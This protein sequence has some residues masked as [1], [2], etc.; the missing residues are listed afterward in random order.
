MNL[1]MRLKLSMLDGIR[2]SRVMRGLA[3]WMC[4]ARAWASPDVARCGALLTRALELSDSFRVLDGA[5]AL[6]ARRAPVGDVMLWSKVVSSQP[7][8]ARALREDKTLSRSI[9][10]KAPG[11]GG[12]KGVLLM[13]FEY[14]WARLLL[15]IPDEEFHW[16]DEEYDLV[17]SASWSATDYAVLALAAS[18]VRGTVFVQSCN[19]EEVARIE[20]FHPRLKCLPTLP[21]DWINPVLYQPKPFA[22]RTKDIVMVANW[23]EF[24]RHWD[25]FRAL[26]QLPPGLKVVLIG[27]KEG[28]RDKEFIRRLAR[29]FGAR[30]E[31]EIH[32]SIPIHAVAAHQ[33]DAKVSVIM[34]RREGCCVAAVESL[35]AGCALAMR[36]DA[37][38]GPLAYI[39]E[40]TGARLRPGRIAE[41]LSS[42]LGRAGQLHP[43]EWAVKNLACHVSHAKVNAVLRDET[44][45]AGR[46]WTRDIVLPQWRPHPTFASRDEQEAMRPAYDELHA[47]WPHVFSPDL[48]S[49]SWR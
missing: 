37:H 19:Y 10:L 47:K 35:F 5:N 41:D 40:Q 21:C 15:G 48:W 28:G 23:G 20:R 33:C 25:L 26:A 39:N 46:P 36:A 8:Y 38:V 22:D 9:V 27:Q 43:R 17:F 49:E 3:A 14:N 2:H 11:A 30:Q 12:E 6:L 29:E 18:K 34:S 4:L 32:E 1:T 7:R 45:R 44:L 42:L 24:K 16:I 13:T 31:L